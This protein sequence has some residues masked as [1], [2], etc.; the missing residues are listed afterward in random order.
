MI[1]LVRSRLLRMSLPILA[2]FPSQLAY[3]M[4]LAYGDLLFRMSS[5]RNE[6]EACVDAIYGKLYSKRERELL[7]R[8]HYRI[9]SCELVD[10]VRIQGDGR[11][12]L[13]LIEVRGIDNLRTA[14]AEGKGA[15]VCSAHLT[16]KEVTAF[17]IIG[18][19]GFPITIIA[20]WS[21]TSNLRHLHFS[22]P[23][24]ERRPGNLRIAVQATAVLR[25]NELVGI[26]IDHAV[27]RSD[28]SRV[29]AFDFLGKKAMFVPG[30]SAIAQLTG[31]PLLVASI[32]RDRDWRH[33]VLE[34]SSPITVQGD[35]LEAY[36]K[37][38]RIIETT[39]VRNPA[40][41]DRLRKRE[42]VAMG[43]LMR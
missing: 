25:H 11:R 10:T 33:Q 22:R 29:A 40:Q 23:N 9:R 37:G 28:N 7:V 3:G 16:R 19:L 43:L 31:S 32:Y 12:L 35:L 41:W 26:M 39:I 27:R 36:E 30:A 8:S 14:L 17:T 6:T 5:S 18:A 2:R 13:S 42:L 21:G 20:R 34:I 24:I 4:A 15:V 1:D 38:L